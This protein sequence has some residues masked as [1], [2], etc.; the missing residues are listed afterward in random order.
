[1]QTDTYVIYSANEAALL[2]AGF[3]SNQHGWVDCVSEATQ[4]DAAERNTLSLP[5]STGQDA[6]WCRAC[7]F[8]S[9]Q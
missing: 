6:R 4:F 7:D 5:M 9:P 3:W 1:M 2:D 8:T